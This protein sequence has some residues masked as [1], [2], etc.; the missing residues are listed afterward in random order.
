MIDFGAWASEAYRIPAA[1]EREP[2]DDGG[3]DASQGQSPPA[4]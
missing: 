1:D 3:E 4:R 2:G